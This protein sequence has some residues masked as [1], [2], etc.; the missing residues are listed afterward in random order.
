[1]ITTRLQPK[2]HRGDT[3]PRVSVRTLILMVELLVAVVAWQ[4]LTA[5]QPANANA[6]WLAA[7][8][9]TAS[10]IQ[11]RVADP[12]ATTPSPVMTGAGTREP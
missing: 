12:A 11:K 1:M 2:Q 3:M 10:S 6:L 5:A 7:D 8:C 4:Y 9:H